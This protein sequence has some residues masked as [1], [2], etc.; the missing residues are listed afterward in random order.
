MQLFLRVWA[1]IERHLQ[2]KGLKQRPKHLVEGTGTHE[3]A[4]NA[5]NQ[6]AWH[7]KFRRPNIILVE[8]VISPSSLDIFLVALLFM[9]I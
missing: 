8:N 4:P 3:P 6:I 9:R 7:V 5:K 1:R 2:E